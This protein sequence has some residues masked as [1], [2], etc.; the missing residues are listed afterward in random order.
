VETSIHESNLRQVRIGLP[1]KITVD[2]DVLTGKTFNGTVAH[3]APLP[4][5]RTRHI[6]PD[7]KLYTTDV[8]LDG[9]DASLRT[10]LSCNVEI[11]I[12]EY[13]DATYVPVQAVLRV[14]GKPTVYVKGANGF[15]A[16]QV[17]VGLDNNRMIKIIN[18]LREGEVV[19]LTPPLKSASVD[20]A[21]EETVERE[22]FTPRENAERDELPKEEK[23]EAGRRISEDESRKEGLPPD[24]DHEKRFERFR[25]M[26]PEERGKIRQERKKRQQQTDDSQ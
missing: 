5:A 25:N 10:G 23:M 26:S 20:T 19:L 11:I 18:G 22:P 21:A 6:N 17:E 8:H 3:I 2:A 4:D 1:A 12:E 14:G 16:R 24:E 9:N 7:L 15:E 13:A